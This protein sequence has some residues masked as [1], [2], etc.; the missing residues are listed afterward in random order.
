MD[1]VCCEPCRQRGVC[2]TERTCCVEC[3]FDLE[4]EKALPYLPYHLQVR[5]REE[6]RWLLA[7]G[8]PRACVVA[9]AK[10]EMEWFRKYCPDWIV[11]VLDKDHQFYERGEL[12]RRVA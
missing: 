2:S 7:N 6:H 8:A 10:R 5:L 3:H 11:A 12:P 9:H 4:E 1:Y